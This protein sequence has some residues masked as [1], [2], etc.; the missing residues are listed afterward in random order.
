M[1]IIFQTI[2]GMIQYVIKTGFW[3]N[4]FSVTT[5]SIISFHGLI[6]SFNINLQNITTQI[7]FD[8]LLYKIRNKMLYYAVIIVID[9]R[10]HQG[11]DYLFK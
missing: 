3:L 7:I 10:R 2:K 6:L 5:W 11:V 8:M 4:I 9:D 1:W